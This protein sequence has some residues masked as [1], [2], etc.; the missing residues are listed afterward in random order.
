MDF[1]SGLSKVRAVERAMAILRAIGE[2][3]RQVTLAELTRKTGFDKSTTRRLLQTLA[4]GDFVEFDEV[5]KSYALGQG[6]LLLVP[7]VRR[8]GDLRDVAAPVLAR[9]SEQT[10]ATSFVWTYFRG[11]GLCL[12]RVKGP[13]VHIDTRWSAIGTLSSLNSGGGPRALMAYLSP[14]DR[15]HVLNSPLP[16]HTPHTVIDPGALEA[17]ATAIRRRGWE[18]AA[19]DYTVGLAG[20][21]A[22]IFDRAG[23]LV[24]S[25]SITNLTPQFGDGDGQPRHLSRVLQAAAEIGANLGPA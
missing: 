7:G 17:A 2:A 20:L 14:A 15:A 22:P 9:L 3:G 16:R 23:T 19:D 13:D 11:F 6:I 25:V 10:G 21:G 5:T 12:D 4:T 18:F 1:A 8:G 24:G